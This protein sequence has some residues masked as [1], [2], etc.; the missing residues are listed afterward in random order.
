MTAALFFFGAGKTGILGEEDSADASER[1]AAEEINGLEDEW[2]LAPGRH[3]SKVG[4]QRPS[5]RVRCI[6]E[7][8]QMVVLGGAAATTSV[9]LVKLLG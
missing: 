9:S 5:L 6:R 3:Y 1:D 8:I 4:A 7:G 2:K